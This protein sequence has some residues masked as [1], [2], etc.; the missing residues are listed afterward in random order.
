[1]SLLYDRFKTRATEL[2]SELDG[3]LHE[4]THQQRLIKRVHRF[5]LN[6]PRGAHQPFAQQL[7]RQELIRLIERR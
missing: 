7:E 2:E 6:L 4:N 5:L 1:M 3:L